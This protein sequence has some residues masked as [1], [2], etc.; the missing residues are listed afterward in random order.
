MPKS[1]QIGITDVASSIP[2][3]NSTNGFA[4]TDVQTAIEEVRT[5]FNGKGYQLTFVANG[6]ATNTWLS[7]E[8]ANVPSSASPA[9][10]AY[11]SRL[12]GITFVNKNV[13]VNTIIRIAISNKATTN[14]TINRAYKWTLDNVRT[15]SKTDDQLGFTL[16]A[17]D[18]VGVYMEDTGGNPSDVVIV[19]HFIVT[20]A[21]SQS[22]TGNHSGNFSSGGFPALTEIFT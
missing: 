7:Q 1:S 12:V 5:S 6:T 4:A 19:M 9:M 20:D 15:A 16:E 10:V 14:N 22:I 3:D 13:N 18:K 8:D 17:G 2:F 21:T 11:K